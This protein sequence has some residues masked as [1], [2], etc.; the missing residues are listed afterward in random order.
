LNNHTTVHTA[1]YISIEYDSFMLLCMLKCIS[2]N[3]AFGNISERKESTHPVGEGLRALPQDNENSVGV[4]ICNSAD[5]SVNC[6]D[7]SPNREVSL[8]DP[9]D[10]ENSVKNGKKYFLI[11]AYSGH[12]IDSCELSVTVKATPYIRAAANAA[13]APNIE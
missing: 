5:P 3:R 1:Q 11:N 10:N 8:I 13:S 6:V 7:I 9:Q 4:E 2:N 12:A